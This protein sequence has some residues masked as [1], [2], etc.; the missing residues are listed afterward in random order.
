MQTANFDN[1][2]LDSLVEVWLTL[3]QAAALLQVSPNKVRQLAKERE[4]I[5]IRTPA[6]REPRVPAEC[7]NDGTVVKGLGGTLV[8]LSDSGF[9]ETE[10][11]TWIFTADESLPGRPIDALRQNRPAEVRRRAQALAF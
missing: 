4:I 8:L 1:D 9:D 3:N 5:A 6:S 10:S 11:A 7:I 2:D